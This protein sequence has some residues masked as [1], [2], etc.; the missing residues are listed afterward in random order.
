[1]Q[2]PFSLNVKKICQVF[3]LFAKFRNIQCLFFSL[4]WISKSLLNQKEDCEYND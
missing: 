2:K 1:M 4:N 3:M